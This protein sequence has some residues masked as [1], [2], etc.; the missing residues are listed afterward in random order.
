MLA[1][2]EARNFNFSEVCFQSKEQ[3]PMG[4][5]GNFLFSNFWPHFPHSLQIRA[6]DTVQVGNVANDVESPMWVGDGWLEKTPKLMF[7]L[8]HLKL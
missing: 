6:N 7:F 5:L 4:Y 3:N 8:T 2:E 1:G